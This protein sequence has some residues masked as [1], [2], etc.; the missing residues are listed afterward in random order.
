MCLLRRLRSFQRGTVGL[1]RST[2]CKVTSCQ[3]WRFEK[4]SPARLES[5][6]THEAWS[7]VS[8]N[9]IILKVWQTATLQP[10]NL[11]KTTVPFRKD[12]DPVINIV[13]AQETD[14]ILTIDFALSKWPHL[15]RAYV[16]TVCSVLSTA[17]Y[18]NQQNQETNFKIIPT[19][20]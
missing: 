5:N 13:S 10:F 18:V 3:I 14:S 11:T 19:L 9:W 7:W 12:L 17:V 16:L 15:H 2:G 20:T 1:C 8:D 6:I 4:N